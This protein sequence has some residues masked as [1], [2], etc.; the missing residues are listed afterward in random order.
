MKNLFARLLNLLFAPQPQPSVF[1]MSGKYLTVVNNF[2]EKIFYDKMYQYIYSE[3]RFDELYIAGDYMSFIE[4][5]QK[6]NELA[7]KMIELFYKETTSEIIVKMSPQI[8]SCFYMV[9]SGEVIPEFEFI[10][11]PEKEKIKE[12]RKNAFLAFIDKITSFKFKMTESELNDKYEGMLNQIY[13]VELTVISESNPGLK[14][15]IYKYLDAKL[16]YLNLEINEFI[17]QNELSLEEKQML[18][19]QNDMDL[20]DV[21]TENERSIKSRI[22]YN[23]FI[24]RLMYI[25]TEKDIL[26]S[27]ISSM[28]QPAPNVDKAQK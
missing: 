17:A 4:S 7:K 14:D 22:N 19:K 23:L 15:Y 25:Q 28:E 21:T 5:F 10:A 13:D 9:Y 8:R 18:S 6:T 20:V 3:N 12:E 2:I 27:P 16:R 11:T 24:L 1:D 26:S